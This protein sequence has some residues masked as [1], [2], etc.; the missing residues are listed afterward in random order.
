[1]TTFQ[2][3]SFVFWWYDVG[4]GT[5]KKV[6]F[7]QSRKFG[8]PESRLGELSVSTPEEMRL[9]TGNRQVWD[10]CYLSDSG[11]GRRLS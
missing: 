11:W 1:M 4:H 9:R 8:G 6:S 3:Y 2:L 10:S 5:I 7:P